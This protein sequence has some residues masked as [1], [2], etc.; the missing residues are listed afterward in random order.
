MV[1]T[2][3]GLSVNGKTSLASKLAKELGFKLFNTGAIYRCIAL[4]IID[5]NLNI[6][7]IDEI[8]ENIKNIKI[9]FIDE[10]IYLNDEDV[11]SKIKTEQISV[12]S[13][14]WA[15][16]LKLKEFVRNYQKKYI[17]K[18]NTVMEG[19]DI[20]TRIAPDAEFRFYVFSTFE[21]RVNRLWNMNMKVS[22]EEI[23]KNLKI[24]DDVDINQ[25]NFVKPENA[26][27]IDTSNISIEE[28]FNIMLKKIKI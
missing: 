18:Y 21:T 15:T 2:I 9:D 4:R 20:G 13:T 27:E 8:L 10:K 1:I 17:S 3:D 24:R 25:G 7:K 11:T 23:I 12:C 19:R 6:E 28:V 16:N 14:Q 5:L 22:K 26:I